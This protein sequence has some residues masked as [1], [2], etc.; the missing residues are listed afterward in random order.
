MADLQVGV[1]GAEI[2]LA[3]VNQDGTA[4]DVSTASEKLIYLMSP[5]GKRLA[6]A[7]AFVNTGT[8][9]LIDYTT[10]AATELDT[11]GQWQ[12]QAKVTIGSTVYPSS[13]QSF[14]VVANLYGV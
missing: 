9:G 6:V 5:K 7:A 8:D 13:I 1:I 2:E 11:P 14:N 10:T 3:L 12:V 4:I